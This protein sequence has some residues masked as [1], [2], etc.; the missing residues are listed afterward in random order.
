MKVSQNVYI[1]PII[2]YQYY[3]KIFHYFPFKNLNKLEYMYKKIYS[4]KTQKKKKM[5]IVNNIML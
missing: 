5:K 2:V 3:N 1:D 4:H